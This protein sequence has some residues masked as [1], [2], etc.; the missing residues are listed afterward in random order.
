MATRLKGI[1]KMQKLE[2]DDPY[3]QILC[4]NEKRGKG[5]P[6][7]HFNQSVGHMVKESIQQLLT[8]SVKNEL[9]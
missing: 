7:Q 8:L 3:C 4:Q 2:K 5:G 9:G 6:I 1:L